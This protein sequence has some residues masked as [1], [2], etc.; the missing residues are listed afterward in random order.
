MLNDLYFP[1]DIPR[2]KS[3]DIPN[4]IACIYFPLVKECVVIVSG[5]F[6]WVFGDSLIFIATCFFFFFFF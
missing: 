1:D 2:H 5:A 4:I 3:S 6:T